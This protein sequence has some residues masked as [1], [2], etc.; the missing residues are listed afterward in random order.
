MVD[1]ALPPS[2]VSVQVQISPAPEENVVTI[3]HLLNRCGMIGIDA[4]VSN[5]VCPLMTLHNV[6]LQ[7]ALEQLEDFWVDW[8]EPVIAAK[9]AHFVV[10]YDRPV[11][12]SMITHARRSDHLFQFGDCSDPESRVSTHLEIQLLPPTELIEIIGTPMLYPET[13]LQMVGKPQIYVRLP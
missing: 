4:I 3:S 10:V 9:R 1:A 2:Q 12:E 6:V 11:F 5:F 8:D 13:D 7:P